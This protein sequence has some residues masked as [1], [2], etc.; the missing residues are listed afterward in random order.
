MVISPRQHFKDNLLESVHLSG[1]FLIKFFP[2]SSDPAVNYSIFVGE[3][4]DYPTDNLLLAISYLVLIFC[5]YNCQ[6]VSCR[7]SLPCLQV[8]N[9]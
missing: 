9:I 6:H 3:K 8:M 7:M 1:S 4:R 5:H 2:V